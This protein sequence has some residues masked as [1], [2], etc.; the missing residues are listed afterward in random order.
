MPTLLEQT[1]ELALDLLEKNGV[2]LPFC[3]LTDAS[4]APVYICPEDQRDLAHDG[5][6]AELQ[7][8]LEKKDVKEFA[9]CADVEAKFAHQE[10]PLRCLR[11]EY[12]GGGS[13]IGIYYF[14]LT[15][16][17]GRASLGKYLFADVPKKELEDNPPAT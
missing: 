5:V 8:R 10:V 6:R 7:R 16:Q 2:L 15:L 9:I 1:A 4:G 14:P 17:D 11:I 12:Q 13:A 3:K